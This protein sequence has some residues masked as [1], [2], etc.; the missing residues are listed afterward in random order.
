MQMFYEILHDSPRN[1]A[2][3]LR[4][5]LLNYQGLNGQFE[6][7]LKRKRILRLVEMRGLVL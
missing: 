7:S 5:N 6:Q 2:R 3:S 1:P 4:S